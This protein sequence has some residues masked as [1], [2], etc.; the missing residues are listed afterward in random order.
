M[1]GSKNGFAISIS[2]AD[3]AS[4][5]I[6]SLNKRIQALSAPAD[7]V[8]KS[9][10]KFGEP[11]GITRFGEGVK[12]LGV[13]LLDSARSM[14][15]LVAPLGMLTSVGSLAGVAA[16]AKQ[17]TDLGVRA[18]ELSTKLMLPT[19]ALG[20]FEG[21]AR[22]AHSSAQDADAALRSMQDALRAVAFQMPE[23]A[24][25]VGLMKQLKMDPGNK[26]KVTDSIE[27]MRQF[28]QGIKDLGLDAAQTNHALR[29]FNIPESM[30]E[31]LSGGAAGVDDYMKK[32]AATGSPL[33]DAMVAGAKEADTAFATLSQTLE[34]SAHRVMQKWEPWFTKWANFS[35]DF[36]K[37]N[38]ELADA[39]LEAGAAG[40]TALTAYGAAK[41]AGRFIPGAGPLGWLSAL[42]FGEE[43]IY[44]GTRIKDTQTQEQE[45]A[46]L[47][48]SMAQ[49][50]PG[51]IVRRPG[52]AAAPLA[53]PRANLGDPRGIRNN[54]P[55][56]LSYVPG[57]GAVANDGRFGIYPTMEAG[58]AADV[59]QIIRNRDVHGLTTLNQMIGDKY[60][61]WAPAGEN[62]VPSYVAA[63]SKAL[64]IRPNDDLDVHNSALMKRLVGAMALHENGRAIDPDAIERGVN[65]VLPPNGIPS[66][67][68]LFGPQRA[69]PRASEGPEHS[70]LPDFPS[71]PRG[72]YDSNGNYIG[73]LPGESAPTVSGGVHVTVEVKNAP[74]GVLA[75]SVAH[76]KHVTTSPPLVAGTM[77]NV[78]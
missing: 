36:L 21:G 65:A 44:E 51:L 55:L 54:N 27:G 63:V 74:H 1:S 60:H 32:A 71:Q 47:G 30:Q 16:L 53:G 12:S 35:S 46:I 5:A 57:Q 13:N 25:F 48:G 49:R 77:P 59:R 24:P 2:V 66:L 22:L 58:V 37:K 31:M 3:K 61:G 4:A 76:G 73:P 67:H 15:R 43:A 40:A 23:G 7:R 6:D 18:G 29:V 10:E 28:A 9:L 34:G 62:D 33:T 52:G 20:K 26:T 8:T 45:N 39:G 78:M 50:F 68:P 19:Y 42:Y 11:T 14:E 75:N 17:Y 70:F 72:R 38:P 41:L 56:N 64:G 69:G